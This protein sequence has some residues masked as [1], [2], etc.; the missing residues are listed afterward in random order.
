M[1][2]FVLLISLPLIVLF[3]IIAVGQLYTIFRRRTREREALNLQTGQPQVYAV[4]HPAQ[5]VEAGHVV[6]Y[7]METNHVMQNRNMNATGDP[8][9]IIR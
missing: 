1:E 3:V 2:D 9:P 7:H 5:V 8:S 6:T 4:E